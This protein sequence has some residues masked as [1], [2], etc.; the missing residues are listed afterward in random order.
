[1]ASKGDRLYACMLVWLMI[2]GT[3]LLFTDRFFFFL[4]FQVY[5]LIKKKSHYRIENLKA[6]FVLVP[7]L[8]GGW[9]SR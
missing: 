8:L 2:P 6:K 9:I 4:C 7:T 1:M 5:N 3:L